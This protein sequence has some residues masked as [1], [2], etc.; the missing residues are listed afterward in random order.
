MKLKNLIGFDPMTGA[1]SI[2]EKD[3][4]GNK[5]TASAAYTVAEVDKLLAS[6]G[7]GGV[8]ADHIALA[9]ALVEPIEQTVPY[10]EIYN[11]F[12][13]EA[14]YGPLEDNS[15]PVED[16]P[17]MAWETGYD[18]AVLY[19]R[20]GYSFTRPTFQT[21]DTGIE[22]QWDSLKKAGWNFL[23]RQMRKAS[24]ALARKR[25]AV[26]R[27]ALITSITA[28]SG[29]DYTVATTM[30]KASVDTI[31]TDAAR[32]GF[33]VTRAVIN[34]A[35]LMDMAT[36]TYPT[37]FLLPSERANEI[38]TTLMITKYGGVDWF[39][40]PHVPVNEI[41]FGGPAEVIG[42]HQT[43]G[44]LSQASDVDITNKVDKHAMYDA[45]HGWY[46]GNGLTL[47]RLTIT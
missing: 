43:R 30:S 25:D 38:L 18:S 44:A 45:E 12:Y 42:W 19:T 11:V 1:Y 16:I 5:L 31:L 33:P 40:N 39:A 23:A 14:G 21:W 4:K 26:A 17:V 46:V 47:R 2:G 9:A 6:V 36:F 15:I 27:Q 3:L 41:L 35:R 20:A 32:I 7:M 24:E 28:Q 34:P 37:G 22:V 10:F 29:H 8:Q 13:M